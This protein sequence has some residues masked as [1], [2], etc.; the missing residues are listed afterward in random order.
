MLRLRLIARDIKEEFQRLAQCQ[1]VDSGIEV[2]QQ[3]S[4]EPEAA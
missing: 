1:T 3:H 2:K 4:T